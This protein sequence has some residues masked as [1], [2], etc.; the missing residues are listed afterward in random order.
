MHPYKILLIYKTQDQYDLLT[1]AIKTY[2]IYELIPVQK[3][4]YDPSRSRDGIDIVM[5][6]GSYDNNT[7]QT[8]ADHA[9]QHTKTFYHIPE[10]YFLEDL[11]AEPERI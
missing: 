1:E 2:P 4:D 11:I 3:M 5:A 10:S 7:L 8:I 9:R 6:A